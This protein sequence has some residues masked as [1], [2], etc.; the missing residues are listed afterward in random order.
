MTQP[1]E[2]FIEH[3]AEAPA[4]PEAAVA[5]LHGVE[6]A[7]RRLAVPDEPVRTV[8]DALGW[9]RHPPTDEHREFWL[10]HTGDGAVAAAAWLS[11][12]QSTTGHAEVLVRPESRGHGLGSALLDRVRTAAAVAGART[13]FG[14]S[15]DEH[16]RNWLV[17][18][19]WRAGHTDVRQV[20]ELTASRFPAA[21][22]ARGAVPSA[23]TDE[24][25]VAHWTG[26][27]PE[28]L[29]AS[30]AMA[31]EAI[32]DAPGDPAEYESWSP[33]RVRDLERSIAARGREMYV[34]VLLAGD[35]GAG[36]TVAGDTGAGFTVAGFTELRVSAEPGS[37]VST[38]ETA[39]LRAYRGRGL[40]VRLKAE[41]L[42]RLRSCRPDVRRVATTNE[43][44]NA[45]MLAVNRRL[46]FVPVARWTRLR[47]PLVA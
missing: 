19:G 39:V 41:S 17:R 45:P 22:P 6:V 5:A 28:H 35:T 14:R 44:G 20:L 16:D 36:F 31:R 18:R 21:D 3:W 12:W 7:C 34:S 43:A 47:L 29:L 1:A 2:P 42:V 38:E 30:Y 46:G 15:A 10:A 33:E 24:V 9:F 13:V 32:N 8:A 37:V 25:R 23:L 26:R 11:V 4:A 27:A 40:A